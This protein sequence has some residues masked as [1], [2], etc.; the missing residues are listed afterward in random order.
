MIG[1]PVY[2]RALTVFCFVFIA[3]AINEKVEEE[4]IGLDTHQPIPA[5]TPSNPMNQKSKR[6]IFS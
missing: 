2:R 3:A 5:V 6:T 1:L 4:K